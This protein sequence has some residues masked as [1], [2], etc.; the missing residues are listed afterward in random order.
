MDNLNATLIRD[1]ADPHAPLDRVGNA[2]RDLRWLADPES[3]ANPDV[4]FGA[5]DEVYNALTAVVAEADRLER[6][7]KYLRT[8]HRAFAKAGREE[9]KKATA[10]LPDPTS[11]P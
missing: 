4:V 11:N 8:M 2:L 6:Q 3:E 9:I 5:I 1:P 10:N 7:A